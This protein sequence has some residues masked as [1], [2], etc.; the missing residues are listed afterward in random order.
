MDIQLTKIKHAKFASQETECFQ[1]VLVVDGVP[2]AIARNEGFGG[3]TNFDPLPGQH[4]RL[5]AAEGWVKELPPIPA[6]PKLGYSME[7]PMNLELYVG[8]LL[9]DWM[10][11]RDLTR[12]LGRTAVIVEDGK[13]F[14]CGWKKL[15][16]TAYTPK[17]W[18]ALRAAHPHATILNLLPFDAALKLYKECT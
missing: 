2:C 15:K 1:A 11:S 16:P 18:D 4:K 5:S 12:L 7:L 8:D 17:H 13:C 3:P 6:D 9:A 14:T 10:R